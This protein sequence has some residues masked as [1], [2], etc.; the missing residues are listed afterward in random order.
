MFDNILA[1]VKNMCVD[2]YVKLYSDEL[3]K[4]PYY[5]FGSSDSID[6]DIF[7]DV[8]FPITKN[9][10]KNSQIIKEL[11]TVL[12]EQLRFRDKKLN[13]NLI[14]IENGII[15]DCYKGTIDECNNCL[16]YTYQYHKQDFPNP[17]ERLVERNIDLKCI[18]TCRELLSFFTRTER[19]SE[20]KS[21]LRGNLVDKLNIL[22]TMKLSSIVD[23]DIERK[24]GEKLPDV[25]KVFCFQLAQCEKLIEGIELFTKHDIVDHYCYFEPFLY[26]SIY[27][28]EDL[29]MIDTVAYI[30]FEKIKHRIPNM[31]TL[32]E[33]LN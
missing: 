20:I 25:L 6:Y 30:L 7:I 33:H 9:H 3:R 31:K 14:R 22:T 12:L 24:K 16:Y 29:D 28:K 13:L 4:F 10:T 32:V 27:T 18:R 2:D 17:I 8:D 1:D 5:I 11:E 23:I 26:R 19:R 15:V 21:A